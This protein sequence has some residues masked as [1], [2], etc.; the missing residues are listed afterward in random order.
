MKVC[1]RSKNEKNPED[2]INFITRIKGIR[3][4]RTLRSCFSGKMK[5]GKS[6]ARSWKDLFLRNG[7]GRT[8]KNRWRGSRL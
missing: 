5:K 7:I 8:F 1:Q 6:L 4:Y 2:F 3:K